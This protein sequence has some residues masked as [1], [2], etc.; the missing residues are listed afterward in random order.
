MFTVIQKQYC[1]TIS[2]FL[3]R[4]LQMPVPSSPF[5]VCGGKLK[6]LPHKH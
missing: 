4:Q 1:G 2:G 6:V 3:L 5:D